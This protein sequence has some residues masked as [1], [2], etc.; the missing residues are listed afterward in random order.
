MEKHGIKLGIV[1]MEASGKTTLVSNLDDALIVS[2]D[3]KAF[4]GKVAHFRYSQYEGLEAFTGTIIDKL[5][6]YKEKYGK[7]PRTLVI[8]SVTHLANNMEKW[9]NDK[10][11]GYT[12]WSA[13]SKDILGF[14]AF[15]E[16]E[17]IPAGINVVFT[18][19]TQ[20]DVDTAKYKIA[21]PGSFGKNG[22]WLSVTDH[23]IFI[24]VKGSK[25]IVHHRTPKY[26]CRTLLSDLP[27]SED[28]SNYDINKHID[29]LEAEVTESEEW[30]L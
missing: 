2:T 14:N 20:Y 18:A 24:E 16:E 9:A 13:L 23:A 10:F 22:S 26:P 12:I 21:S 25:R 6:A 19:H 28:M 3:N 7:Y 5:E 15:L 4:R 8:D 11:T 27:D 29:M 1:A 17:I 30:S